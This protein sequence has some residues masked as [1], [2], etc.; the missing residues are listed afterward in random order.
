MNKEINELWKAWLQADEKTR[1]SLYNA[2]IFFSHATD[3][4]VRNMY[5]AVGTPDGHL[6]TKEDALKM[7]DE[8][9]KWITLHPNCG[10]A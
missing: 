10:I 9:E 6:K 4:E 7:R 2:A 8:I 5:D 3:E 1:Q